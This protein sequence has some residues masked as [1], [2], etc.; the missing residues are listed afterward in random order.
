[1]S[2][3]PPGYAV[4]CGKPPLHSRFKKG[5]SGN[6]QS[7]RRHAKRLA[8]VLQEVLDRPVTRAGA[9]RG[10]RRKTTRREAIVAGLVEK[11][12]AGDSRATKL[13]LDLA[14][15]T[16]L[17]ADPAP[18][19]GDADDPRLFLLRELARLSATGAADAKSDA[20]S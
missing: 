5:N 2:K 4:G 18:V 14:L 9:R 3:E 16:E 8:T 11:S 6:P 7:G 19:S 17:A 12:A 10:A 13:L 15:K 1:M 20:D